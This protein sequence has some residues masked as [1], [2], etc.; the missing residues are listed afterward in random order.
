MKT[1][2]Y[3]GSRF[4]AALL[5]YVLGRGANALASVALFVLLA[6]VLDVSNYGA[7]VAIWALLELLLSLGNVGSEWITATELPR[8]RQARDWAAL[9]ALLRR[10]LGLQ[11]ISF[12]SLGL[13]LGLGGPVLSGWLKLDL[14]A[15]L[16]FWLGLHLFV[17]GLGRSLRDQFLSSLLLQWLGQT[18][19][20]L[21]NLLVIAGLAWAA[22]NQQA[23]LAFVVPLETLAST[24]AMLLALANLLWQLRHREPAPEPV[25]APHWPTLRRM[26]WHAWLGTIGALLLS[27]QLLLL[28]AARLIGTEALALLGFARNLAEQL[29]RFMPIE[30]GFM[31]LR[32]YLV[33][34]RK[35]MPGAAM[36]VYRGQVAWKANALVL[37]PLWVVVLVWGEEVA[38]WVG[39]PKLAGAGPALLAW[40]TWVLVWS[41]HRLVDIWAHLLG[42]SASVGRASV[43]LVLAPLLLLLAFKLSP[44]AAVY[45]LALIELVYILA[46][47]RG[48]LAGLQAYPWKSLRA[49]RWCGAWLA[50]AASALVLSHTGL[51]WMLAAALT[52]AAWVGLAWL[53]GAFNR[54]DLRRWRL[55]GEAC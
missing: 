7:Y 42:R 37:F 1:Q 36:L 34:A 13:L 26:A 27:P 8:L 38:A 18:V 48:A 53:S 33:A 39:G 25:E 30:F 45:L 16:W 21:R 49:G 22:S 9:R 31:I 28:L 40:V 20:L 19:Q 24:L 29:R 54:D 55:G 43:L 50:C 11:A 15:M 5:H 14:G 10:I 44:L 41:H 6:R 46:V 52:V 51:H 35:A 4:R 3:A 17:E 12:G 23:S 32:T 2:A 47:G